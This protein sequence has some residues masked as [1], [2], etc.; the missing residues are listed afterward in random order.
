V[1]VGRA[2]VVLVLVVLV[3]VVLVVLVLVLVLVV[4]TR[5]V[6][7]IGAASGPG[8]SP[9]RANANTPPTQ[10]ARE[11]RTIVT[12]RA[13]DGRAARSRTSIIL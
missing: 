8:T 5:V 1:G 7:T 3:L 11:H 12:R 13:A 2:I 10:T 9:P 4:L 6:D